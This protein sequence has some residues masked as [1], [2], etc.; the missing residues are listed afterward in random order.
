[1]YSLNEI[2]LISE[3]FSV[4]K[5]LGWFKKLKISEIP[6]QKTGA[7]CLKLIILK[8]IDVKKII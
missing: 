5:K 8:I 2:R 6:P 1:M 7:S 4:G 3:L